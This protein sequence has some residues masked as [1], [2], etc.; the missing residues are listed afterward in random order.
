MLDGRR[1]LVTGASSGIG[2]GLS[3][4]YAAAGATVWGVGRDPDRLDETARACPDG[5]FIAVRADLTAPDGPKTVFDSLDGSPL[6][7]VVHAAGLLGPANTTLADYPDDAWEQVFA[8]NLTA[9]QH[10]HRAVLPALDSGRRPAV[11]ALSSTVGREARAGW[12]AYAI[13][14]H[15]LEAWVATLA[16][17]WS[18]RA[19][20]VN[21]GATRTPM[22]AAAAP[23]EDPM[24]LPT[25]QD[26]SPVFLR[27]ARSDADEPSGGRYD[28]RDHLDG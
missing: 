15:A 13:S 12:G 14:K 24:T 23:G 7:V 18:G 20:S 11:I 8:V 25:P 2:R 19:Y 16:L 27:L 28:A 4:V 9:V 5:A 26:I 17:E 3:E 10:L 21:P 6:D 22:R 1:I